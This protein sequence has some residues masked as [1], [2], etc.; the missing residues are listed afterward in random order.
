MDR[1]GVTDL[2]KLTSQQAKSLMADEIAKQ[3][4][5]E[6]QAKENMAFKESLKAFT[7][8]LL[9]LFTM[10]QPVFEVLGKGI[11]FFTETLNKFPMAKWI[12]AIVGLTAALGLFALK[13]AGSIAGS[14]GKLGGLLGRGPAGGAVQAAQQTAGP[15][16]P[17]AK[18]A[19]G[20][21]TLGKSLVSFARELKKIGNMKIKLKGILN[22]A[23]AIALL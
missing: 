2:S 1:Q 15:A 3:Q 22:F 17:S 8:S 21:K 13:A 23:A 6:K 4:N 9:N 11:Q 7:D 16:I 19:K 18:G 20:G 14:V 12:L 5:L 10:F